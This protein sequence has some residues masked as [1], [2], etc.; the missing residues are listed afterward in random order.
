MAE[1]YMMV[2]QD[3]YDDRDIGEL[4]GR[5]DRAVQGGGGITSGML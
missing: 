4:S 1:K 5:S 3:M 2:V